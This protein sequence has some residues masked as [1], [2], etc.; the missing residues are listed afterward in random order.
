MKD[1]R[2]IK[3]T[4]VEGEVVGYTSADQDIAIFETEDRTVSVKVEELTHVTWQYV[5]RQARIRL[6]RL[7]YTIFSDK[8]EKYMKY[9][10]LVVIVYT[11]VMFLL[12]VLTKQILG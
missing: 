12:G 9:A 5:K 4:F 7:A 3:R 8:A 1:I 2:R 11:V 6:K 10:G